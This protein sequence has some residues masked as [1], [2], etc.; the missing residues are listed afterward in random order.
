MRTATRCVHHDLIEDLDQAFK[1]AVGPFAKAAQ[2]WVL[3]T[4]SYRSELT[5]LVSVL[6]LVCGSYARAGVV[7][8]IRRTKMP[9]GQMC[10]DLCG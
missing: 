10:I 5:I 4:K 6:L 8:V 3:H 7:F 9:I 2:H 1:A